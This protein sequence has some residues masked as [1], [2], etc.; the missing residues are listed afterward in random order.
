MSNPVMEGLFVCEFLSYNTCT[1]L[2]SLGSGRNV[3]HSEPKQKTG[4][5]VVLRTTP[6]WT[7]KYFQIGIDLTNL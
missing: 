5:L 6:F 2:R 3:Y 4:S 7:Q 1:V